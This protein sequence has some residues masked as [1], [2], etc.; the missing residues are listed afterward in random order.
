M[1]RTSVVFNFMVYFNSE[2][3]TKEAINNDTDFMFQDVNSRV[4]LDETP[5]TEAI[6]DAVLHR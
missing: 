4:H 3:L 5:T 2:P 6:S 1:M